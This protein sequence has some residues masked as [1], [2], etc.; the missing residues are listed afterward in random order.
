[1]SVIKKCVIL[2]YFGNFNNYFHLWLYSCSMQKDIDF[3]IVTDAK[4][5]ADVPANVKVIHKTFQELKN[6]FE[7]KFGFRINLETPYKLCDYKP[8]YGY[9]FQKEIEGYD[10]WGYCDCDTLF[11]R[12][13]E[14]LTEQD[15]VEYDKL[16]RLGHLSFIRNKEE[17]N[18]NFL[19]Y[20]TYK[21][22][23]TH[24]LIY[25]YDESVMGYHKGFNGELLASGYRVFQR[26]NVVGDIEFK[27]FPFRV[28]TALQ[29][30]C[31]FEFRDGIL[32]RLDKL[33]RGGVKRTEM[34]YLHLQKRAMELEK[35]LDPKHFLIVPNRFCK[36]DESLLYDPAFW[37]EVS[38]E[39]PS[40][41][42]F[43]AE[44]RRLFK[45]DLLRFWYEP[46]KVKAILY[47]CFGLKSFAD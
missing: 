46:K 21:M 17:I 24:S 8:Y 44:K 14:F 34:A 16:L 7:E 31:V 38:A 19:S 35:D 11:G 13:G 22:V 1:M 42:N 3:L 30:P 29:T 18:T 20:R 45:R 2:P 4:I 41:F 37:E 32:Y 23:V 28:V 25:S 6:Q 40:Y 9:L 47:H 10:F 33:E 15:F 5:M 27:Y 39:D 43:A 26:D 12:I 36:Y